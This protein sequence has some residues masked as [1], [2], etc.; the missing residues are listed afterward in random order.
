MDKTDLH[1]K[2]YD[3]QDLKYREMQ[4]RIIPSIDP[5]S[6]IGV[7]TPALKT[8]AKDILKTGNYKEFLEELPHRYFEENQLQAFIISGIKDLNECME[9]LERFLPY[10]DNWATCDQ[11]SP[12]IFK[13]HKDVLLAHIKEWIKSE[14]LYTVRFGVGMLMEHFLDDDYDPAYHEMVA[15]LRSEDYYVNMMIAWYFATAL[16][17]QYERILPYIEEKRLEDWTHNK[18]IQKSV[19]SR[20]IKD[21]QKEYL[22]T[23]KAQ[24]GKR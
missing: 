7:R 2:L 4:I 22:K 14:K 10:V 3:L 9:E 6:V 23:L 24:G 20:R 13:K 8:M 19:E 18:A 21:E 16:A 12:K 5:G 15:E 11:M 17:K 1:R